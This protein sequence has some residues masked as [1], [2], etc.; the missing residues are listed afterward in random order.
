M[1]WTQLRTDNRNPLN[2]EN[3][4]RIAG[5]PTEQPSNWSFN[6]LPIRLLETS[7]RNEFW[8]DKSIHLFPKES[9]YALLL[10]GFS[11][12]VYLQHSPDKDN[13][14]RR[15]WLQKPKWDLACLVEMD[16]SLCFY[17]GSLPSLRPSLKQTDRWILVLQ[18]PAYPRV[19]LLT[20]RL[21]RNLLFDEIVS[22]TT[23]YI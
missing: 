3:G 19:T 12:C 5:R 22:W 21:D 16:Q 14:I 17:Q 13:Y 9:N 11:F 7:A 23:A 10:G 18:D 20:R 8:D 15:W 6:K 4:V 1:Q 2:S